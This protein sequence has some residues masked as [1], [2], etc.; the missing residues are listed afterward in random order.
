MLIFVTV[1]M[2]KSQIMNKKY[3]TFLGFL[4]GLNLCIGQTVQDIIDQVDINRME[5]IISVLS[6]EEAAMINGTSQTITT[7]VHSSNDLA[8]DY[9][10]EQFLAMDNLS[11][12]IQNF[13]TTGK[14]VIATQ[15]GQTN[16]DDIYIIC[17]HYDSVAA[18]CADDN[19]TGTAAVLEI[20]RILST[21]CTDNT[22]V[23]ALWDE[24]EIGLRGSAFYANEAADDTN[25]NTRDNI[26]GVLNM[27]M[28]GYDG[29]A[30]GTAGDN[31]FDIDYRAQ[32]G[33]S[34]GMK[35]DLLA[36]LGTYTF[37]LS[38]IEV[39][40]GTTASDHA[41]FWTH[42]YSALLVGESWE[43]NDQTPFYHTSSDQLATLDL[44]YYHE[45]VKF[46]AAYTATQAGLI[47]VDN[48]VTQNATS[49]ISN[50]VTGAYQWFN[51]DTDSAIPGATNQTYSP[52]I[53]G[54]YAVEVTSGSCTERSD[55]FAFTV[56]ST[57]T[58]T[59]N[60]IVVFP[61]PVTTVLKID[62]ALNLD[63][64]IALYD[65]AGKI[66]HQSESSETQTTIEMNDMSAGVYFLK[67]SSGQKEGTY[68]IVKE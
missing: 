5:T 66:I 26:L 62:N 35:D 21:Q 12:Q 31:E 68:K 24:E 28:M 44:P 63:I 49:L 67:L 10:E 22:I 29:D 47:N 42:N 38:V 46:V 3:V 11:V 50:D 33:D 16:P 23:Y 54:N 65:V 43:T 39:S 9:L 40:N 17:A 59:E 18:F 52:T 45:M 7:R 61:N 32:F 48:T 25:G 53:S 13:N 14:N 8:T 55:C 1:A 57:E 2:K 60:E 64:N 30:P 27:D 37:D 6:G 15:I 41:S 56:L 19:A 51:C 34:E 20:A 36:I 58:F 4:C